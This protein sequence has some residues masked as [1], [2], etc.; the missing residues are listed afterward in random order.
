MCIRDRL[1]PAGHAYA[2]VIPAFVDAAL[3]STPLTVHGQGT[4][5]RDFTHVSTVC[6]T[7]LRALE[8]RTSCPDPVN[9]AFGTKTSLLEVIELLGQELDVPIV[10]E[11]TDSRVGDVPH[12]QADHGL[13]D[14]LLPGITPKPFIDGLRETIAWMRSLESSESQTISLPKA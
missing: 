7:I 9:L 11:H 5:S 2:A 3:R 1:Q 12:S 14:S 13:L 6:R 8:E 10:V 4:Q